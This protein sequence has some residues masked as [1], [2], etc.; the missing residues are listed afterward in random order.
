MTLEEVGCWFPGD[1]HEGEVW[2]YK[3]DRLQWA[4]LLIQPKYHRPPARGSQTS[5]PG[6]W[7]D[8]MLCPKHAKQLNAKRV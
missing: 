6:W 7:D 1:D 4:A 5:G 2:S 3:V 8:P